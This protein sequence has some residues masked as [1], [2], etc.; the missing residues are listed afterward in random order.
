MRR[1]ITKKTWDQCSVSG[2]VLK[3]L[4][5]LNIMS[6]EINSNNQNKKELKLEM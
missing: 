1:N 3:L 5:V 2:I 4:K 6:F